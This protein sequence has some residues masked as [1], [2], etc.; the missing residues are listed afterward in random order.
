M[1]SDKEHIKSVQIESVVRRICNPLQK[2]V[3]VNMNTLLR[4]L[5]LA[6]TYNCNDE[7]NI[8]D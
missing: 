3:S 2:H 5:N 6:D 1:I 8:E 7:V 4:D